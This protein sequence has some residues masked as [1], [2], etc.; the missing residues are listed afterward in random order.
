MPK[1]SNLFWKRLAIFTGSLLVCTAALEVTLRLM[2]PVRTF[3]NPLTSFNEFDAEVGW[4]GTPNATGRFH[5]TDFNVL[6]RND[7]D[8]FRAKESA[9]RPG[10]DSPV[11]AVFGA[12]LTWGWGVE[13]GQ[14]F[15]DVMQNQ[16]GSRADVRN[17]G[18]FAYGT[19]Q[20]FLLLK[21]MLRNGLRPR[22]VVVMVFSRDLEENIDANP[23]HPFVSVDGTNVTLRNSPV[24]K[25]IISPI[26]KLAKNSYLLSS[27]AYLSDFAKEKKRVDN[28]QQAAFRDGRLAEEPQLAMRFMLQ[29][30]KQLC[31]QQGIRLCFVYE[32]FLDDVQ[33][34]DD[35][36]PRKVIK[37]LCDQEG[38]E[39]IDPTTYFQ[40]AAGGN[41][42]RFF[43]Q[44]DKH[45]SPDGHA[46][47]GKMLADFF[48][49]ELGLPRPQP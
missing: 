36:E 6:V 47:V 15:T 21:K 44:H 38:V 26:R 9:V 5:R 37:C 45:W 19:V 8:G 13:N 46:L 20:E 18:V 34:K 33:S 43:F 1:N 42:A 32:P 10:A 12:S 16:L 2:S 22:E 30:F 40:Q 11:I 29:Q 48:G 24:A 23:T 14:V 28:M 31:G 35:S 7:A 39:I 17:C 4:I 41:P 49:K 27:I 25:R 3:V